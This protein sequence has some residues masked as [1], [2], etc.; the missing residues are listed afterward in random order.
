MQINFVIFLKFL[1]LTNW[2]SKI[3]S[4]NALMRN[5]KLSKR[6]GDPEI[7]NIFFVDLLEQHKF[8]ILRFCTIYAKNIEDRE[9]LFQI[10]IEEKV[11]LL[12]ETSE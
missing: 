4:P 3:I 10:E 12:G 6:E 1:S 7:G 9:D 2:K 5:C 8:K 11:Q